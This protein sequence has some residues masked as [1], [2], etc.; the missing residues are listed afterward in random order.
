LTGLTGYSGFFHF[1]A[2]PVALEGNENGK[3][4]STCGGKI[5]SEYFI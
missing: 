1:P 2:Y 4:L 3:V 5:H